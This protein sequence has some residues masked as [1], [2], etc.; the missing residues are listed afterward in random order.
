MS[1]IVYNKSKTRSMSAACCFNEWDLFIVEW[2]CLPV[3]ERFP[4]LPNPTMS[5]TMST[6]KNQDW[7]SMSENVKQ[8]GPGTRYR[9]VTPFAL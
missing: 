1:G 2:G 8:A 7:L 3:G 4:P 6:T 5:T 9:N